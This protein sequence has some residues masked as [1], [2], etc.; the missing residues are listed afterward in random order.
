MP[1]MEKA[2]KIA[3]W[4]SKLRYLAFKSKFIRQIEFSENLENLYGKCYWRVRSSSPTT[5]IPLKVQ[6]VIKVITYN[7]MK[8]RSRDA[9]VRILGLLGPCKGPMMSYLSAISY[10]RKVK[11]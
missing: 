11:G 1:E 4:P 2:S 9:N 7:F 6:T 5:L 8:S 10:V 3:K